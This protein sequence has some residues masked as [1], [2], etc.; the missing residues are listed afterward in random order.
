MGKPLNYNHELRTVGMSNA[1]SGVLGG[2]TGSYIFSQTI[3]NLRARVE[4]RITGCALA[5]ANR[6][7]SFLI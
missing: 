5:P 6:R 3:F 1:L 4:S 2:Y 7:P